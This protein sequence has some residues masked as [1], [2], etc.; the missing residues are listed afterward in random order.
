MPL[1]DTVTTPLLIP[2]EAAEMDGL[3][4]LTPPNSSFKENLAG[5]HPVRVLRNQELD[6]R[7]EA[8]RKFWRGLPETDRNRL[9]ALLGLRQALESDDRLSVKKREDAYL[10][11]IPEILAAA[12]MQSHK[13][14][15]IEKVLEAAQNAPQYGMSDSMRADLIAGLSGLFAKRE[16]SL[17]VLQRLLNHAVRNARL[18][19]WRRTNEKA[20]LPA[21]YCPDAATALYVSALVKIGGFRALLVCPHCGNAFLQQRSDQDYCSIRCREAHRVARWRA[22]KIRSKLKRRRHT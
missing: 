19:L 16:R 21:I 6:M 11:I 12:P 20:L 18:M 2:C 22:E 13:K 3:V 9:L 5:E 15:L 10:K 8:G 4:N 7:S 1:R 17:A 14:S